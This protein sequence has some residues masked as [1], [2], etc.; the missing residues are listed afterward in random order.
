M[1]HPFKSAIVLFPAVYDYRITSV[2]EYCSA[3]C[4]CKKNHIMYTFIIIF[5]FYF[6]ELRFSFQTNDRLC[7]VMEFAIGGDLYYHL[8][9]EVQLMKE[10]FSESRSKFY[11]AEIV[12]ALGYLHANNIVY[13]DLK[14]SFIMSSWKVVLLK[15]KNSVRKSASRQRRPHQ[16]SRLWALQGGYIVRRPNEYVLRNARISG[17]RGL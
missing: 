11:G 7:F 16:D 13:R 17:S 4:L 8:N 5:T 3:W 2:R 6:Q 9:R 14:V 15:E 12:S 10:G 1:W